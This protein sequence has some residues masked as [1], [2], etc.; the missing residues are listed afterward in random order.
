MAVVTTAAFMPVGRVAIARSFAFLEF[1]TGVFSLVGLSITVMIGLAATDLSADPPP[2]PAADRAPG[3]R[4]HRHGLLSDPRRD[5][6]HRGTRPPVG[7][8]G[9]VPRQSPARSGRARHAGQLPHDRGD[10]DRVTRASYAQSRRPGRWRVLH[11]TAYA[12]WGLALVH[13]LDVRP[14][15]TWVVV[16]YSICIGLVTLAL[17][18]RLFVALSRRTHLAAAQ[19]TR[20]M[21][22]TRQPE[23]TAATPLATNVPIP[24]LA[25]PSGPWNRT[26][27][28]TDRRTRLPRPTSAG[29]VTTGRTS[30]CARV[31]RCPRRA[32]PS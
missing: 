27:R 28:P 31:D 21:R 12:A 9:P 25:Q 24:T 18:V 26:K 29:Q 17:L 22:P 20:R 7:P 13:G 4:G 30:H 15:L 2:D 5:E 19:T 16:S 10:L 6:A 1:F 8:G 3:H 14:A 32:N 23:P 11:A